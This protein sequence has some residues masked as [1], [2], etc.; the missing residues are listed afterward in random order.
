MKL[1]IS[2]C[3]K[4]NVELTKRQYLVTTITPATTKDNEF[5]VEVSGKFKREFELNQN[6]EGPCM[7]PKGRTNNN[8][9]IA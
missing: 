3:V 4:M 6:T 5:K 9:E 1:K 7:L 2:G 8:S